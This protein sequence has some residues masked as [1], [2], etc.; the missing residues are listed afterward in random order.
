MKS[1]HRLFPLKAILNWNRCIEAAKQMYQ[2][3][4]LDGDKTAMNSNFR[5]HALRIALTDGTEK[6]Y[7]TMLEAF[8]KTTDAAEVNSILMSLSYFTDPALIKR[9]LVFSLTDEVNPGQ[10][11]FPH[12]F[13]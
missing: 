13:N 9:T 8:R 2:G 3:Y 4:Y 7:D 12:H 10:V 11:Y 1:R 6:D 5:D